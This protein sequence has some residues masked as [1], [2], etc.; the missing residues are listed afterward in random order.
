MI[1]IISNGNTNRSY[2]WSYAPLIEASL[3]LVFYNYE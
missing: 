3:N 1:I 2:D